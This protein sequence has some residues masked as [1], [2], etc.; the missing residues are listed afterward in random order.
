MAA[1]NTVTRSFDP[2]SPVWIPFVINIGFLA[3]IGGVALYNYIDTPIN[4]PKV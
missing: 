4:L 1:V 3:I 2:A